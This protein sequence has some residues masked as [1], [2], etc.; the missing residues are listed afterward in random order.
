MKKLADYAREQHLD[1]RTLWRNVKSGTANIETE[2]KNGRIFVKESI[3]T[4]KLQKF[5]DQDGKF[6]TPVL[7]G[8]EMKASTVR[9]NAAATSSPVD[10]YAQIRN[11]IEPFNSASSR[12]NTADSGSM[13]PVADAIYLCQKAYYNF[14]VFRNIIDTMTEF[15]CSNIYLQGGNA[16]AR[17][18][19]YNFL[20]EIQIDSLLDKFF[21]EM[22]RSGS[23][24]L[25]RFQVTP[26]PEDISRLNKA[27]GATAAENT[28]LPSKYMIVNPYDIGVQANL[29][30]G[31]NIIFYKRLNGYEIH[32]LRARET[33]EEKAFFDSLPEV[34]KKQ[35]MAGAG[36][37]IVPLDPERIYAVFYKKQD[38]E[39]MPIPMGYPV[40]KDIEW[41][42]EMK[43]VDMA[44]ART[45][46]QVVLLVNMGYEAKDGTYMFDNKAAEA[47]QQLFANESVGKVLV[48]D[49]NTKLTWAIP[50]IGDFLDPKKYQ[51][52]NQDIKEGLN[53]I[54]TGGDSKF[55][56]QFISVKLFVER[57][58]QGR[59]MFLKQ[60]LIPEMKK[61]C[62]TMGF[63][64]CPTPKFEDID[65]RDEAEWERI[66]TQLTSLGVLT[67]QEGLD[68]IETGKLPTS[69]ES[70]EHQME[71]RKMRDTGLYEPLVGGPYDNLKLAKVASDAKMQMQKNNT[72]PIS[73]RPSGTTAPQTTKKVGISRGSVEDAIGNMELISI[74][75]LKNNFILASQL[76]TNI[77]D[78][79]SKLK[80]IKKF[81]DQHNLIIDEIAD[82]IMANNPSSDWTNKEIMEKYVKEPINNNLER[83]KQIDAA[84]LEHQIDPKLAV[85][86]IDCKK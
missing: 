20:Q 22:Y 26:K 3:Q 13:F 37:C 21:R 81:N 1:Y 76:R 75:K 85:Y 60:F 55:A 71:Y 9:R 50:A 15:S 31:S 36:T 63:K 18:F 30:F 52:V 17:N 54:L 68:S 46:Q 49:F 5:V 73:G 67:P 32:R 77:S 34:T 27:Y 24:I 16:K 47:M 66:V 64:S 39:S 80:N 79:F 41:K 19:F 40:L 2:T 83:I 14:A 59:E 48:A 45:M 58:K 69:E 8:K 42:S 86:L 33:P 35:I 72:P 38:Y 70:L 74:S 51:I 57:L 65:L 6:Y 43:H 78:F 44:V 7:S 23:P 10:E 29:V 53:Y 84:A 11:G 28:M 82:I 61:I 56:N 4:N 25:Y 12:N 62:D